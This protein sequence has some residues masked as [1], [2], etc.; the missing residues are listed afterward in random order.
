MG[1]ASTGEKTRMEI[2]DL[3]QEMGFT[4]TSLI[5]LFVPQGSVLVLA[6]LR[7]NISR[8][9]IVTRASS[10]HCLCTHN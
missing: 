7:L 1:G 6:P 5:M 9:G 3:E 8:L 4:I 10:K 2:E